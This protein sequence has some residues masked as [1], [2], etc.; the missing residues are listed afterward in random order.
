MKFES[1]SERI[2]LDAGKQ[3]LTTLIVLFERL[4]IV[5]RNMGSDEV[6]MQFERAS[7]YRELLKSLLDGDELWL[8]V[9]PGT[10]YPHATNRT[11]SLT[12]IRDGN[13]IGKNCL[14]GD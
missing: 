13:V 7:R 1:L 12:V 5:S 4:A 3:F 10:Q 2:S 8:S 11:F 14:F 6:T 9:E